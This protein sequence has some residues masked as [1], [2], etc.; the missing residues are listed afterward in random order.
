MRKGRI[1]AAT[2]AI[3]LSVATLATVTGAST[4]ASDQP[5]ATTAKTSYVVLADEG[6]SAKTLAAKLRASGVTVTSVN[7]RSVSSP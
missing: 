6:T 4:A 3:C 7:E 1:L 5:A 2:A